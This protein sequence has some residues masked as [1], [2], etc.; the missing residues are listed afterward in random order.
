MALRHSIFGIF[1]PSY[2]GKLT[3]VRYLVETGQFTATPIWTTR[4]RRKGEI[5]PTVRF[6][7]EDR[8]ADVTA[9]GSWICFDTDRNRYAID[10][11]ECR[12][13]ARDAHVLVGLTPRTKPML[14]AALNEIETV[15]LIPQ[16]QSELERHLLHDETR[17]LQER[18][19]RARR[20]REDLSAGMTADIVLKVRFLSDP[21]ERRKQLEGFAVEMLRAWPAH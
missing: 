5:D 3:L 9:Q 20:N 16:D 2:V 15:F 6:V 8:M 17:P 13:L 21:I 7:S 18:Q 12:A 19:D 4:P 10:V 1:G 14:K 11:A